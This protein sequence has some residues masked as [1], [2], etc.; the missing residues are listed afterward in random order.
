MAL[1]DLYETD[2]IL[3]AP[4]SAL[5]LRKPLTGLIH[6]SDLGSQYTSRAL[7][8]F[9]QQHKIRL[10]HSKT[11]CAYDNATLSAL[12]GAATVIANDLD[13]RHLEILKAGALPRDR[14]RLHLRSGPLE[15]L[16]FK[17]NSLGAVL[18]SR[19]LN[20]LSPA[21]IVDVLHRL[22]QWLEKDGKVFLLQV[23]GFFFRCWQ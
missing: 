13:P 12:A 17:G 22:Y 3:Q 18:A 14:H 19:L 7:S 10:S 1:K 8:E 20:F 2:L 6:H 23:Y 21:E 15:D 16:V 11:G 4:R 9:A 5:L